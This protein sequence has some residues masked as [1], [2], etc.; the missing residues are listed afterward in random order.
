MTTVYLSLGSNLG[1]RAKYLAEARL[2]LEKDF[3]NARFSS[4]YETEPVDYKNQ[5]WFLNQVAEVQTGMEPKSLLEW[6]RQ[7]EAS[8]GRQRDI[9][10][11][12]RSLDVDI[13][14]YGDLVYQDQELVLPH[15]AIRF[16]R[17]VLIPLAELAE[18]KILP[19][20]KLTV[21]E[22]LKLTQDDSKVNPYA[23]S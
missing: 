16:R 13:L 9:P 21:K 2:A 1:D 5:G 3:A 15:P 18:A 14:L 10:K 12:P 19:D 22:A 20:L 11:G 6:A 8:Q 23:P 7:L 4:V 17:H